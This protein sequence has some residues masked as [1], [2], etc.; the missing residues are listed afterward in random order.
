M[1]S[2]DVRVSVYASSPLLCDRFSLAARAG[3]ECEG[4]RRAGVFTHL[5][6]NEAFSICM[7]MNTLRQRQARV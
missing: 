3:L 7:K 4:S 6:S 1:S 5:H 2:N